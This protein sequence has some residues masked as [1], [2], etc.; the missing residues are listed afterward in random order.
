MSPSNSAS[1]VM[2]RVH[3]DPVEGADQ[4]FT[5]DFLD[6]A[7]VKRLLQEETDDILRLLKEMNIEASAYEE[8]ALRYRK[9]YKIALRW[10]KNYTDLEFRSLG[11]YTRGDLEAIAAADD[12]F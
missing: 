1:A 6:F 2:S 9:A 12:A 5:A 10:I 7:L 11:S 3:V 4:L 8:A